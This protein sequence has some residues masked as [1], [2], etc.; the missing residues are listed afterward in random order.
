MLGPF[1]DLG[2]DLPLLAPLHPV[3]S[4]ILLRP[5]TPAKPVLTHRVNQKFN[6]ASLDDESLAKYSLMT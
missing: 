6:F 1:N 3:C 2:I 4:I 5:Q